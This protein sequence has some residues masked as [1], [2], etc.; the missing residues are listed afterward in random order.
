M[1]FSA[2]Y[3]ESVY[4]L[5]ESGLFKDPR[6]FTLGACL[7]R[8]YADLGIEQFLVVGNSKLSSLFTGVISNLPE[9]HE[10]FFTRVPNTTELISEILIRGYDLADCQFEHQRNW[11]LSIVNK[12]L[13]KSYQF[14]DPEIEVLLAKALLELVSKDKS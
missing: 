6:K 3:I 2:N 10:H 7:I 9:G 12:T 14:G 8:G 1:I 4:Q 11:K 5:G 13:N